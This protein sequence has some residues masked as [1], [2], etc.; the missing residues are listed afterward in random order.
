MTDAT[1]AS[2]APNPAAAPGASVPEARRRRGGPF[3]RRDH[4]GPRATLRQLWPYLFAEKP[5]MT[6][7]VAISIAG[8]AFSLA[9]PLL[10]SW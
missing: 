10:H 6:L 7:I 8:S 9:Q 1:P 3:A 2:S 4:A 5:M